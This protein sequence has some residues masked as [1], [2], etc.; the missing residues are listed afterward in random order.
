MKQDLTPRQYGSPMHRFVSFAHE[1]AMVAIFEPCRYRKLSG[2]EVFLMLLTKHETLCHRTFFG[3]R[4]ALSVAYCAARLSRLVCCAG[5]LAGQHRLSPIYGLV[6]RSQRNPHNLFRQYLL[7]V[8][9]AL[10]HTR[11]PVRPMDD[12]ALLQH[13]QCDYTSMGSRPYL[14][15]AVLGVRFLSAFSASFSALFTNPHPG[16]TPCA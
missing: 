10:R 15:F 12:V 4:C 8:D 13:T 16:A 9:V 1:R 6:L 2:K 3:L 14:P 5:H 11:L 7:V